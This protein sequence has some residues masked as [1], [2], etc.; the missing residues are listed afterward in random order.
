MTSTDAVLKAAQQLCADG[1]EINRHTVRELTQLKMTIVDDRLKYLVANHQ[2][3]RIVKGVYLL[4]PPELEKRAFRVSIVSPSVSD[5]E[6]ILMGGSDDIVRIEIEGEPVIALNRRSQY[7]MTLLTDGTAR[8]VE[9]E[10]QMLLAQ[11]SHG[12]AEGIWRTTS[13][14]VRWQ[15]SFTELYSLLFRSG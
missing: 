5:A 14:L 1:K 3:A 4:A 15:S 9:E 8:I 6:H 11:L 2:L 13:Y 10:G 7:A 12:E